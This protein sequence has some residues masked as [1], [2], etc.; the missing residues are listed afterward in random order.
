MDNDTSRTAGAH[1]G[2]SVSKDKINDYSII[3][4]NGQHRGTNTRTNTN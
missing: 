4:N 3:N 1:N 2:L